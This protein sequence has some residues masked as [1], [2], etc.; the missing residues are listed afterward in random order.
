MM[1]CSCCC[2]PRV[3]LW[4]ANSNSAVFGISYS[5]IERVYSDMDIGVDNNANWTGNLN[6]YVLIFQPMAISAPSWWAAITGAMWKGRLHLTAEHNGFSNT[7]TY[8]NGLSALTGIGVTARDI[9]PGCGHVGSAQVDDLT[10][11]IGGIFY[12]DSSEVTGGT[13]L[14]VSDS[15]GTHPNTPWIAHNVVGHIDFI[16]AGDQDHIA[17]TCGYANNQ[18]KIFF[19]NLYNVAMP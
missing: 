9:D 14:C 16:V 13:A 8:V 10:A 2:K 1:M 3:L 5:D 18:N 4:F 17:D 6:D 12:A 15:A 11:G 19:Q 7:I